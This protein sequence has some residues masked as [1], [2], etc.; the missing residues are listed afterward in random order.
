MNLSPNMG[1][2]RCVIFVCIPCLENM[3]IKLSQLQWIRPLV[4]ISRGKQNVNANAEPTCPAGFDSS[5]THLIS[6]ICRE[7]T[8]VTNIQPEEGISPRPLPSPAPLPL[9]YIRL[10]HPTQPTRLFK[11]GNY[12]SRLIILITLESIEMPHR[13]RPPQGSWPARQRSAGKGRPPRVGC[14]GSA[15]E[16]R[17]AHSVMSLPKN[18]SWPALPDFPLVG[19]ARLCNVPRS[20][21]YTLKRIHFTV[22][23][24]S[25]T[26]W[27]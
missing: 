9:R 24:C 11:C 12:F 25:I 13:R 5:L 22:F 19:A 3:E 2:N 6:V 20:M 10:L 17:G 27:S 7:I 18:K 23:W 26:E 1:W 15:A 21:P 14:R 8:R 16:D 4:S